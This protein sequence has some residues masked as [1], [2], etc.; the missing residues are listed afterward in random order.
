MYLSYVVIKFIE[1]TKVIKEL[2]IISL[3]KLSFEGK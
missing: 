1:F 3:M 2:E